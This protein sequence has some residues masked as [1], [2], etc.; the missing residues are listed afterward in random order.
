MPDT[1]NYD[2]KEFRP[3]NLTE[4]EARDFGTLR[5]HRQ[6]EA[7]RAGAV[8]AGSAPSRSA[9]PTYRTRETASVAPT[10]ESFT[11]GNPFY[12]HHSDYEPSTIQPSYK[13]DEPEI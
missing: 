3:R 4:Q 1:R 12:K 11:A 5:D 8:S 2:E 9:P 13:S 6:E 7:R 10:Y